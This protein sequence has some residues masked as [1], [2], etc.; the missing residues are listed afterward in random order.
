MKKLR[1]T[2]FLDNG[3]FYHLRNTYRVTIEKLLIAVNKK[4]QEELIPFQYDLDSLTIL[5][6]QRFAE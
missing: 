4:F 1:V 3:S 2:V 5:T 6:Y